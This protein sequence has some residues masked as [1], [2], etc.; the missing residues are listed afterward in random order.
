M[1]R[2][3]VTKMP[4]N[5][6][7]RI[8]I[9][10]NFFS[11]TYDTSLLSPSLVDNRISLIEVQSFIGKIQEETNFMYLIRISFKR[12]FFG[13]ICFLLVIAIRISFLLEI[14]LFPYHLL[15]LIYF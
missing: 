4:Q 9:P 13:L 6:E 3:S 2:R 7:R 1:F 8:I 15:H 10:L 5:D 12:M 14:S 11:G